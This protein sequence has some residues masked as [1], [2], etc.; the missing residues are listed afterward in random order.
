MLAFDKVIMYC[1]PADEDG[2]R[3]TFPVDANTKQD[4]ARLWAS[5][6]TSWHG[7]PKVD[8]YIVE[9]DN[10]GF[11][12]VTIVD[13]DYR[14]NGGRAYQVV[15]KHGKDKFQFDLREATLVD[16][17][18]NAGIQAGGKLNGTFCFVK[19]GAQTNIVREGS[20]AH[21]K[22]VSEQ[23]KRQN[24]KVIKKSDLI[25]GHQY[26]NVLKETAV[27][28]GNFYVPVFKKDSFEEYTVKPVM[29]FVREGSQTLQP[30]IDEGPGTY[31]AHKST[32]EW[33]SLGS[34]HFKGSHSYRIDK[35]KKVDVPSA[36][37]IA[38]R[39]REQAAS[40][41]KKKVAGGKKSYHCWFYEYAIMP[42][43]TDAVATTKKD[44]KVN[45]H[46]LKDMANIYYA[47]NRNKQPR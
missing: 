36:E 7:S 5:K 21:K 8:P 42:I 10:K 33:V 2:V 40:Y 31:E 18:E 13:L 45:K 30:W 4:S 35:G 16:V 44:V 28:L 34:L 11:D 41:Y 47:H 1:R 38:E 15:M 26:E 17:I 29:L 14:G 43:V 23:E 27:F 19:D 12:S 39:V 6:T 32:Y 25:V 46:L 3:H 22:A 37:I 20:A 24:N 9:L